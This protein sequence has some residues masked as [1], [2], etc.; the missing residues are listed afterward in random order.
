MD[1]Q[2]KYTLATGHSVIFTHQFRIYLSK[3]D[4]G[5]LFFERK[6]FIF[7]TLSLMQVDA[8]YTLDQRHVP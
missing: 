2:T 6:C 3:K 8:P 4:Y 1:E 5:T 7:F